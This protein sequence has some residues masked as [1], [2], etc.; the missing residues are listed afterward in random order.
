MGGG[1]IDTP[2]R[3][4]RRAGMEVVSQLRLSGV[5]AEWFK[6]VLEDGHTYGVN[7]VTLLGTYGAANIPERK[8]DR[9]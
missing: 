8:G 2:Q 5:S 6:E 7:R 3:W 9:C 4:G 1:S